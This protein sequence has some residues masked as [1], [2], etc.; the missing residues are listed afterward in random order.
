[1][2]KLHDHGQ[3][4]IN[5]LCACL[6]D[7]MWELSWDHA[8]HVYNRTL[9]HC[10]KWQTPYDALRSNKPDVSHLHVFRCGAYVFLLEDVRANKLSPK[11]ETIVYLGQPASYKGFCF[12]CITTGHI[13]IGATTVFD[14]TFFPCCPDVKQRHFTEL[15]DQPPTENRYPDNL[16]DQSDETNFGNNLPF[17]PENDDHPL[18]SPPSEPEVPV[19]PDH[20]MEY[21]LH[22]QGNPPVPLPQW[23]DDD[24]PSWC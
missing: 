16:I 21:L 2:S 7:T 18:S 5:A 17:S 3:G 24:S 12:Y 15:G 9:I 20:D 8:I 6:T 10:L 11:S 4:A 22:T 14:D 23:R 19:V 1:M 13:F